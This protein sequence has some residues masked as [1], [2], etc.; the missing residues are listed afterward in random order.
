MRTRKIQALVAVVVIAFVGAFLFFRTQLKW[1]GLITS[2]QLYQCQP[3]I[4][5]EEA[6]ALAGWR[7]MG[8]MEVIGVTADTVVMKDVDDP[9][10]TVIY[11]FRVPAGSDQFTTGGCWLIHADI[12]KVVM[13]GPCG[14]LVELR[15]VDAVELTRPGEASEGGSTSEIQL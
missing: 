15:D 4:G 5:R 9:D 6:Q 8:V 12:R 3:H 13:H 14:F 7:I 11:G 10:F 1:V 2:Y